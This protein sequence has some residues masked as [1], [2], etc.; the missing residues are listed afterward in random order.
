[1]SR[2]PDST[3]TIP[4]GFGE[5]FASPGDHIGQFYQSKE[6]CHAMLVAFLKAGHDAGEK[7]V[8]LSPS[9][10]LG[11]LQEALSTAGIDLER[12]Q[13]SGQLT[14]YGGESEPEELAELLRQAMADIPGRFPRLRWAGDMTWAVKK[15]ATTEKLME[16]E[17]HCNCVEEPS[18]LFLC[19]YDLRLFPG[20]VVMDAMRTHPVCIVGRNIHQ[21]PLY[22]RPERFMEEVRGRESTALLR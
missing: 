13:A 9:D 16:W 4:L 5:L 6:E 10:E 1:M 22:E 8:C 11:D 3:G 19:Q 21:N 18:P 20:N 14:F 7:C 12:A 15:V 17:S 2:R